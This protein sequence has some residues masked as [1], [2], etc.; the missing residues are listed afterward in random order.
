M[1]LT[2]YTGFGDALQAG[3]GSCIA[4]DGEWIVYAT[5]DD[6]KSSSVGS[7]TDEPLCIDE[8]IDR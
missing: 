5:A 3:N 1:A 2:S 6:M 4:A 7:S 8:G